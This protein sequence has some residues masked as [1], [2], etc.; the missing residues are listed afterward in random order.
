[1]S[2][3]ANSFHLEI[4]V[5]STSSIPLANFYTAVVRQSSSADLKVLLRPEMHPQVERIQLQKIDGTILDQEDI[6]GTFDIVPYVFT[7]DKSGP[8]SEEF[9]CADNAEEQLQVATSWLL[10]SSDFHGHWENLV[11][12][13]GLKLSLLSYAE[14][15]LLLSEKGVN[16][17]F[18][19]WNQVIL[20]HGPVCTF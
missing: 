15:L 4:A 7:L 19:S 10:P 5:N 20:L 9:D 1:M 14:T 16:Q 12:E 11:F 8:Q 17:N 6:D 2:F 18:L 3:N 13:E